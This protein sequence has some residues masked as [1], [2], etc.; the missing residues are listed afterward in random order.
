MFVAA[1]P[2][3]PLI[4]LLSNLFEIRVDAY[5]YIHNF[6]RPVARRAECIGA[7]YNILATITSVSRGDFLILVQTN[8]L[9]VGLDKLRLRVALVA[10]HKFFYVLTVAMTLSTTCSGPKSSRWSLKTDEEI[11]KTVEISGKF[12]ENPERCTKR[13]RKCTL[14]KHF[15]RSLSYSDDAKV[16]QW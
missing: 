5:N 15:L 10:M 2:L 6:R 11:K 16:A 8:F 13:I 12:R 4:A 1:F 3:A 9:F 7:W 14:L